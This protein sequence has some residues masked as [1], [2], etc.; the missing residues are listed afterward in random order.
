MKRY[1]ITV[2]AKTTVGGTVV[3]GWHRGRINGQAMA[4]EGDEVK[5]P[6]CD[7]T[8]TIVCVG[9]RLPEEMDG[10]MPALDGD[11]C[12]CKCDPSP[13]LIANQTMRNP[14]RRPKRDNRQSNRAPPDLH[15]PRAPR[16][17]LSASCRG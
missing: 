3:S 2:G 10:L 9:P 4:R 14:R 5:C 17:R 13:K 15:L 6:E 12:K 8:G 7:S 1:N 11:L 16:H